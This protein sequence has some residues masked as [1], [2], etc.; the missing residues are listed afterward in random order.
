MGAEQF[1]LF[2]EDERPAAPAA[3]KPLRR[4]VEVFFAVRPDAATAARI[5]SVRRELAAAH[6]LKRAGVEAHRLHVT[7]C[8]LD[9][10]A[11]SSDVARVCEVAS[12]LSPPDLAVAFD[13]A[14]SFSGGPLVLTGGEGL[15][16]L[17]VYQ[18]GLRHALKQAGFDVPSYTL[19]LT[20]MYGDRRQLVP[21]TPVDPVGW[22]VNELVLVHSHVGQ[23]VHEDV[24]YWPPR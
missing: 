10:E 13:Q 8:P 5:D 3:P 21:P 24:A 12:R 9:I 16:A 1:S 11:G 15:G 20:L 23:H 14:M 17:R 19:H 6:G 4:R 7:L 2:G 18:Q 22:R